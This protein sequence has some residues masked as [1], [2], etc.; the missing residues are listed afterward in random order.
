MDN[1]LIYYYWFRYTNTVNFE[2]RES[3]T[4]LKQFTI[5]NSYS[6]LKGTRQN[7]QSINI[8]AYNEYHQV[9]AKKHSIFI[10]QIGNTNRATFINNVYV[11]F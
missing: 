3:T 5:I 7:M 2:T 10:F 8:F 4:S 9:F 1:Q 11:C 6:F